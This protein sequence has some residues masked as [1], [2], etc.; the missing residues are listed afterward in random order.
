LR[1]ALDAQKQSADK[2]N[3]NALQGNILKH[4]Y[5]TNR[6]LYEDL[7]Q[8][9]KEISI[10]AS[11]KSSNIWIVDPAR[12]PRLPAEPNIPR[13][14][15]LSLASGL[16]GGVL[17]ALGLTQMH[18]NIST[19]EQAVIL[20][21]LPS[22]GVVPL[23]GARG[24][25]GAAAQ[26]NCVNGTVK[27]ELVGIQRPMSLAAEC[28]KS[29][30]TSILLSHPI[31]PAAIL[32]TSALPGEGKTTV[33]TNL[34]IA[35]A[36]LRKRVLLVDA[37]LRRPSVHRAMRLKSDTG[38]GALLRKSASFEDVVIHCPDAA[39]LTILPAGRINL[40]EDTELLMSGFKELLDRWREQFDNVI[41]DTP[42]VLPMSDALRMSVEADSV[43]L[44]IRSGHSA[45]DAFL[46]AQDLLLKVNAHLTGFVLNCAELDSSIF[47]YHYGYYGKDQLK[48]LE[49]GT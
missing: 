7:L 23:L 17:L 38:L 41:I 8:K 12:P 2:L 20:S 35:L 34:A 16:V 6:K 15:A 32:V 1:K 10:S 33:S 25:N 37:D 44:V 26:L 22:L 36:R 42:P 46:S 3:A 18:E 4:E 27:P 21:S 30:L 47:R 43:I 5:E 28:Y 14:F 49:G 31:P 9:Q 40:P 24:K 39:N 19:L 48:E 11:L 29:V 45:K 13:N